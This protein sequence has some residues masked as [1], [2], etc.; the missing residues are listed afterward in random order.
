LT[1]II[2]P[3]SNLTA[4]ADKTRQDFLENQLKDAAS[5]GRRL[6]LELATVALHN[7]PG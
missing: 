4:F 1:R 2:C 3:S 5:S 6:G 7:L